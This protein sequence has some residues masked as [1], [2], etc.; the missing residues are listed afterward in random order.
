[1]GHRI[2]LLILVLLLLSTSGTT[3]AH[4]YLIRA[5][6]EDRSVLQRA[7]TRLQYWFS[8]NL[9]PQFSAI[10]VR[11][12][13]GEAIA[14][15][16]LAPDNPALLTVRLPRDLPD[17]AYIADMR[18]AFASDGHVVAQS[19]VFFVGQV[20][21]DVTGAAAT[22]QANGLE[23][24]WRTLVLS[25]T[26]LLFGAFMLYSVVLVPAWGN[27]DY[28]A[29]L[30]PPRLMRRLNLIISAALV[31]TLAGNGL[32]LLQQA[33]VFFNADLGQVVSQGLWN[34]ARIGT[35]FGDV[36]NVRLLLLILVAG[37]HGISLFY[38]SEQPET[39]RPFWS[40]NAWGM[41]LVVGSFSVTSH[42][43]GSTLWPWLGI[44]LDWLHALAV[45]VWAGG[46]AALVLVLP[47]A[48]APYTGDDR[49]MALLAALRRFSRLAVV[50]VALVITTGLYSAAAWITKPADLTQTSFGSAL[51]VKLVLVAALLLVGLAHHIA[52]RPERYARWSG[53]INRVNSF[54]PTLRL[55][56]AL[57][58][59][60]M[61]AVSQLSATPVPVP[62]EVRQ[63]PP[64]PSASQTVN[65]LDVTMTITPGGPGVNT[66]DTL[67]TQNGQPLD[68]L[69]VRVQWV[70][71]ARDRRS[72]W[73]AAEDADSG[74]YVAAGADLDQAGDWWALVDVRDSQGNRT[75]AAFD[76][77]IQTEAAVIQTRPPGPANL[78]A[79]ALT[80]A[81]IGWVLYPAGKAVYH[82]LDLR[83]AAVT[84]ALG[85]VIATGFFT[86]LGVRMIQDTQARYEATIN[87]PPS[88]VNPVLPD[89]A[90]LQRGGA[91][92]KAGC[93]TWDNLPDYRALVERLPRT[94][95]DE[96]FKA[97][98]EGWQTLPGCA[99]SLSAHEQWDVVNYFR[100]K[101]Q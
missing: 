57:V 61:V 32:A 97:V 72:A 96:L 15:G 6:P 35:R 17:G 41:A 19:N 99:A 93:S 76:W 12:P 20:V 38:W 87:P 34:V 51:L 73:K 71:P 24:V 70:D 77:R 58:L 42:A 86:L 22:N 81:A 65:G 92:Y 30:L 53:I 89:A 80:L 82:Q 69:H 95:D 91:L 101:E 90:S 37:L 78:A 48:L 26:L 56:T 98:R 1:V 3:S 46:L 39:V 47:T 66:Y 54:I 4:G 8:E 84:I 79:L 94:R 27:P 10:T 21:A 5:I 62:D 16:G 64:A 50:C 36:W 59:A 23:V 40:A 55:E 31:V 83:P 43:A 88:V 14:T 45:G 52:L 33:M 75:R 63:A 13:T 60:V 2:A 44:A 49:R 68:N 100:T 29:G 25:A 18:L 7:P 85:A 28:R 9:E 67:V 11:T 74:L